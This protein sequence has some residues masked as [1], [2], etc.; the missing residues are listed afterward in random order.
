M[1]EFFWSLRWHV[2]RIAVGN[3]THVAAGLLDGWRAFRREF[4][5]TW[6]SRWK[7]SERKEFRRRWEASR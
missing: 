6:S 1:S 7:A 4:A 3:T 5:R 2:A